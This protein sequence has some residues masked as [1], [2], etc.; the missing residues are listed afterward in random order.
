MDSEYPEW[1]LMIPKKTGKMS[2]TELINRDYFRGRF[3]SPRKDSVAGT[4]MIF[5]W[6]ETPIQ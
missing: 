3:A 5:N 2:D 6:E 4:K 1:R